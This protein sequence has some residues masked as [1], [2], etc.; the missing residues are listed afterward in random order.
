MRVLLFHLNALEVGQW[1]DTVR[2]GRCFLW[3]VSAVSY[4]RWSRMDTE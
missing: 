3:F 2:T 1:I 4:Q